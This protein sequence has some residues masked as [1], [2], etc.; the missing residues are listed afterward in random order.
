VSRS[1]ILLAL[2]LAAACHS[3][4]GAIAAPDERAADGETLRPARP[5]RAR[6]NRLQ[7]NRLQP[8]ILLVLIDDLGWKDLH[9][10][11]NERL[12]TP[13]VDRLA[14]DGMRFTDAYAASPVCSPTRAAILTGKSPARLRITNHIPDQA[15]FTPAGAA[16][17][18]APMLD[19]LPLEHETIAERLRAA[20][21]ATGFFGKWH[22]AGSA[23]WKEGAVG[24]TRYYPERQGFDINRG[25][26]AAGG[27]PSFFSPFQ[28][29]NLPDRRDGEYLPDRLAAE[30][31][32]F[33]REHREQPFFIALWNY[34]VHWPMAAPEKLIAKYEA[35]KGPGVKDPRY[36]AMVEAMDAAFGRVIAALDALGLRDETLVVFTSDNGP[37]LGVADAEPLRSGKGYL[38]E[39]GLRV[40]LIVR[41]PGVVAP[42]SVC[43][44]PVVLTDLFATFVEA[45][46]LE[47]DPQV[48]NDGE[49]LVPLLRGGESLRRDA[50]CFHYP[51]Y[52][53]HGGNRLGGA[54]RAGRFKLIEHFDDGSTEL[55]DLERDIG[56]TRDVA[57]EHADRAADL[58]EKL[59]A[60]RREVDAAMPI[61]RAAAAEK[62]AR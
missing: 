59:R 47:L 9:C 56:E 24:D 11:G 8:N 41:W 15:R 50:L 23:N 55:Y 16:L 51:N 4:G 38:Y 31:I 5:N 36:A 20:G 19:W 37:F 27:P 22:L 26:C 57:S 43:A 49:S 48:P 40:P 46:G 13:H 7:P 35:R 10:Q 42:G 3:S 32:A 33:G 2:A 54:V 45:A 44:T 60:W 14:A 18:S 12:D 53:F 25:G 58:L 21:Y 1:A 30:A 62:D 61:R 28:L 34:T 6:P 52:A 39:G 17:D 29:H